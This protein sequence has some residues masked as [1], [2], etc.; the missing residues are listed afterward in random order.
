M[1]K[2]PIGIQTFPE[3]INGNYVYVDKTPLIHRMIDTGKVYFLSRPRRFGKSLTISTLEEIFKGNKALFEGLW[4]YDK[5]DWQPY[6][7]IHI[8][9]SEVSKKNLPLIDSIHLILDEI[10]DEYHTSLKQANF[11]L[12]FRELIKA[13][14]K[15]KPVAILID[16]YDKPI[17]DYLE[18]EKI[19]QAKE[20][21]DTLKDLYSVL[22]GNDA[23]IKFLLMTGVSKFSKVSI[24]SD[25]NHLS[26]LSL[27][28]H[29]AGLT[30]Y[31]HEELK[32]YFADYLKN[33]SEVLGIENIMEEITT[34]YDGYSWD[35]KTFLFNPFSILNFFENNK[36]DDYWFRSGTPTFLMKLIKERSY[37]VSWMEGMCVDSN[38]FEQFEIEKLEITPLLMQ[39]G[40]ITIKDYDFRS[41]L[42]TLK[43]PNNEVRKSFND[44][45]LR[46]LSENPGDK[47]AI[48]LYDLT[49]SL[50]N[51]ETEKFFSLIKILFKN[52]T[53]PLIDEKEKYY[54]SIFYT[55]LKLLEFRI[56][57]EVL[58]ADGR[59]DA[60]I[61]TEKF[62][63]IIEF[64]MGTA[65][66]AIAQIKRKEYALKY[67]NDPRKVVLLGIGFSAELKNVENY[68]EE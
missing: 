58:T 35:G 26:E 66:E 30:G 50:E 38:V 64:K 36:F 7:V 34:W 10:A 51:K 67:A 68:V 55:M 56:E 52:I 2:L 12:K 4:I 15:D 31:T 6:P 40:Y 53:Y 3:M 32:T 11:G 47:N 59:I 28:P 23:N 25:L 45:L 49:Y 39:T 54:H 44:F 14:A 13:L 17:I 57:T 37:D 8:D 42:Y 27:N 22:K 19:Q 63:Y 24:F 41:G 21:R 62:I 20:N 18:K 60:V 5:I 9:F 33:S 46:T 61:K 29:Y 65:E 48:L 16:E 43:Y 1:K